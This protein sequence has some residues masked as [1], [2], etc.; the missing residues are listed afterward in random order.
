MPVFGTPVTLEEFKDKMD[1]R[2]KFYRDEMIPASAM[3]MS[4]E[5]GNIIRAKSADGKTITTETY[6]MTKHG[7][8]T[9]SAKVGV[10]YMYLE[11]CPPPLRASNFNYWIERRGSKELFVRLDSYPDGKEKIRAVLSNRYAD[12][13]NTELAKALLEKANKSYD[14]E[15]RFEDREALLVG[16]MVAK[17]KDF[18]VQEFNSGIHVRNSEIGLAKLTLEAMV[19]SRAHQ[20]GIILREMAGFSEKHIG[21]K[22]QFAKLFGESIDK[23]MSNI[24]GIIRTMYDLKNIKV[25]DIPE[26]L[27]VICQANMVQ[28]SGKEAL[29]RA[30]LVIETK[31]LFDVVC[32]FMRAAT[33][34]EL[35]LDE[36]EELQRVG[37]DIVL[38]AKRYQKWL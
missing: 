24:P 3:R 18:E 19:Y 1:E 11:R 15:M 20:S 22:K 9:F 10:P 7:F 37:G 29:A 28:E 25:L 26:I 23:I 5:T 30:Q 38:K 31:T 35:T 34:S 2:A 12:M 6:P 4:D 21:D 13:P 8:A 27:D 14:F 17:S 16:Q 32:M 36:R 33:D